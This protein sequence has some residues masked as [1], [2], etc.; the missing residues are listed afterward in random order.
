MKNSRIISALKI[1]GLFGQY[2]VNITFNDLT[3]IVGKNGLGK[4]TILK[5]LQGFTTGKH[6]LNYSEICES[7]EVF[8]EDGNII[9]FGK[10][11]DEMG[12]ASASKGLYHHL[13]YDKEGIDSIFE[14]VKGLNS[15]LSE[16]E[17][18]K[19]AKKLIE[20]ALNSESFINILKNGYSEILQKNKKQIYSNKWHVN[21]LIKT[22]NVR[23]LSTVNISANASSRKDLGNGVELNLIDL[24]IREE[25]I[26]LIKNGNKKSINTL[27]CNI[28]A[29]FSD[30]GK[31]AVFNNYDL[32]F[33]TAIGKQI[34]TQQLSS[35]E[36]QLV[37]ILATVANTV[38][39]KTLLLMDEPEVSLHLDWQEK[40]LNAIRNVNNKIQIIAVT[41]SPG[42]I[43]NGYMDAYIEMN[44]VMKS[45]SHG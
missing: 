40:I 16:E 43:M 2:D 44:D 17:K 3:V 5:I 27:L 1:E 42:I 6:E 30:S 31:I 37:Y 35:G 8:Y 36:R 4:S 11:S 12:I 10:I 13:M 23:Y 26:S 20:N 15:Q 29:L 19:I 18:E 34:T 33:I 22:V 25:I 21:E 32:Y 28:N 24:A 7:I 14:E 45:V 9:S 38:G 39:K 41:H